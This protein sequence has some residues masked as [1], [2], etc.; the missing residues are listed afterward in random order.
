MNKNTF[1]KYSQRMYV[2]MY[3]TYALNYLFL[4]KSE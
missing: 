1:A 3:V 2:Y 4:I